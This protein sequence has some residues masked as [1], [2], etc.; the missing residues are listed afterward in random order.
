M[1]F[2]AISKRFLP[3]LLPGASQPLRFK[4]CRKTRCL[5]VFAMVSWFNSLTAIGIVIS[6][7]ELQLASLL[8]HDQK[9][10]SKL[11]RSKIIP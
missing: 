1:T 7:V 5:L 2:I 10:G 9:K 6:S 4:K 11:R 3:I 8:Q